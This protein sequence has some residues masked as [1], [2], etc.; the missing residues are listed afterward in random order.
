MS[1]SIFEASTIAGL[2]AATIAAGVLRG[3]SGF[4]GGLV[5]APFFIRMIGPTGSVVL[6]SMIHLLTSF[7]GV[8]RSVS[9]VDFR[10]VGP[11]TALAV[12]SVPLGVLLLD[13]LDPHLIK[14]AVAVVVIA[15]ALAMTFGARIPGSP[16][17]DL[18]LSWWE[19]S[20]AS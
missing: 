10:I 15:L 9:L 2:I 7:Q 13:E 17:Q 1:A 6:I 18:G 20:A 19:C 3:Y 8:R 16:E 12:L 11:L 4:G 14:T 5:M